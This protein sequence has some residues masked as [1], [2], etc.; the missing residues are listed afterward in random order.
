MSLSKYL[1]DSSGK[2]NRINILNLIDEEKSKKLNYSGKK[3]KSWP[4]TRKRFETK[5]KRNSVY[6][7]EFLI[8]I[9][10]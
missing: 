9:I 10:L 3:R 6:F 2:L 5:I 8:Y 1:N 7:I 4:Q